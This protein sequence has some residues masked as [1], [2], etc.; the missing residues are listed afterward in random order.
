M[1]ILADVAIPLIAIIL[2]FFINWNKN[3]KYITT[4]A[5]IL[6]FFL[7]I[8][9]GIKIFNL[10]KIVVFKNWIS[11]DGAGF[12]ILSLISF[13]YFTSSLYSIGYIDIEKKEDIRRYYLNYNLFIFSMLAVPVLSEPNLT[14]IAVE[15][16][17]IFSIM[18]VAFNHSNESLEASWKYTVITLMGAIIGLAGFFI[19]YGISKKAGITCYSW[20]N[21][22]NV[23]QN[24]DKTLYKFSFIL[25]LIGFGAKVGFFPLHTWLPDAHSQAPSSICALLSGIET[26]VVLYVI[27]KV[28]H[29]NSFIHVNNLNLICMIFG[30]VSAV[31]A[32]FLIIQTKLYKRIFAFS[33]VEHMGIILFAFSIPAISGKYGAFYQILGHALTKS[34]CFYAAGMILYLTGFKEISK[35]KNFIKYDKF[36][37]L[38]L[39]SGAFAIAGAPPFILFFSEFSI[40]KAGFLNKFY[41]L[42]SILI[43]AILVAFAGIVNH[44]SRMVFDKGENSFK[45]EKKVPFTCKLAT[46]IT[47]LIVVVTGFYPQI[48]KKFVQIAVLSFGGN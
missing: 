13:L 11:L 44:I 21:L 10:H 2:C 35:I 14:W 41:I 24:L 29:L 20:D 18:L 46:I 12:F 22:I 27:L 34:L 19:L 37:S 40:I 6:N 39:I 47:F 45:I 16:T 4:F 23:A 48:I 1:L 5:A 28:F 26:T 25:I 17:T 3:S 32:G 30:V 43:F 7:T 33:T 15:F 38:I 31:I 8:I 9:I 36:S 42:T